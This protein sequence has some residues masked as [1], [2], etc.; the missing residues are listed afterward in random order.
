MHSIRAAAVAAAS[1]L[2]GAAIRGTVFRLSVASGD[3]E[4]IACLRWPARNVQRTS[5][6]LKEHRML[7]IFAYLQNLPVRRDDRGITAVEYALLLLGIAVAVAIV[8]IFF[9]KQLAPVIKNFTT[10]F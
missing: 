1:L 10:K 4:G 7:K 8:A 9:G 5:R 2:A 6:P 3:T